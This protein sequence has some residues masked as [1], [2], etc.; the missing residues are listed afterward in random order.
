M[1]LPRPARRES[2]R[3]RGAALAA[4]NFPMA[5]MLLGVQALDAATSLTIILLAEGVGVLLLQGLLT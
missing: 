1:T 5:R 3:L 2:A 4:Q